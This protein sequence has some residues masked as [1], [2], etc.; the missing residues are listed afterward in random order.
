MVPLLIQLYSEGAK[1]P[2]QVISWTLYCPGLGGLSAPGSLS[3]FLSPLAPD[4][5][6]RLTPPLNTPIQPNATDS[7]KEKELKLL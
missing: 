3:L 1:P 6:E 4:V 5:R 2:D 7:S